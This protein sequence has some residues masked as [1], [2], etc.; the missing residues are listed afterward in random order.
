MAVNP[1]PLVRR[2]VRAS[3]LSR[4][5]IAE[6]RR[7]IAVLHGVPRKLPLDTLARG[8]V[9]DRLVRLDVELGK[10]GSRAGDFAAARSHFDRS[11]AAGTWRFHCAAMAM[12]I[13]PGLLRGAY[14][15]SA[16]AAAPH[17]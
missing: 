11:R 6:L 9:H 14:L 13:A 1:S 16:S 4:D 5:S 7:A 3:N 12:R 10:R 15:R 17:P 2:T 8:L